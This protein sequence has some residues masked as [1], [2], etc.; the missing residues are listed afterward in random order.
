MADK[1][2]NS[3]SVYTI[4]NEAYKQAVGDKAVATQDLADFVENGVAYDT[5]IADN[6]WKDQFTK[7]LLQQCVKNFYLDTDYSEEY[8]DPFYEDARRFG[9]IVQLISAEAPEVQASHAWQQFVSGTTKVGQYDVYIPIVDAKCAGKSSSWELPITITNELWDPAFK[10]EGELTKFISFIMLAVKNAITQHLEDAQRLNVANFIGEKLAYAA[11]QGAEGIHKIDL[12]ALYEAETGDQTITT[13]EAFMANDKC[14]RFAAEKLDEYIGYM[15]RQSALFNTEQKTKFV[16]RNRLVCEVLQRFESRMK[17]V[18]YADAYNLE[19]VKLP[20][21]KTVPFWQGFGEPD[22]T[23]GAVDVDEVSAIKIKTA[24]G[25]TVSQ[26]GIVALLADKWAV[27][28]TILDQ[29][30]AHEHFDFENL[31]TYMYQFR[32]QRINNLQQ[33]AIVFTVED[34]S[35]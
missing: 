11:S 6:A 14:M 8:S 13:A 5:L 26:T 35:E 31:D 23:S 20:E 27:M 32:D 34:A 19:F 17:S 15:G 3:N 24:S 29:R 2:L 22:S 30:V 25:E 7:A 1:Y 10:N 12:R 33:N 28:H 18:S 16:P 9:A 4:V 21:H